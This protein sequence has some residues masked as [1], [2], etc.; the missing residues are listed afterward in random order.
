MYV[1]NTS[2]VTAAEG[3]TDISCEEDERIN[4]I[5]YFIIARRVNLGVIGVFCTLLGYKHLLQQD[6]R[7]HKQKKK[8]IVLHL[9][10]LSLLTGIPGACLMGQILKLL[11]G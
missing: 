4:L 6:L 11:K 9:E 7:E 8:P 1:T 2:I 10:H 5:G 3:M